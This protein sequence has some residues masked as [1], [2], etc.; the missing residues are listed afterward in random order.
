MQTKVA[1][2]YENKV[3]FEV[4]GIRLLPAKGDTRCCMNSNKW[5]K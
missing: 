4:F 1:D 3:N 2:G 5:L